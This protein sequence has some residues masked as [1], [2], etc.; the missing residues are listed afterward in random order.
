M[1]DVGHLIRPRAQY[2]FYPYIL[3]K[4]ECALNE[5]ECSASTHTPGFISFAHTR[6]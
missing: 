3:F 6:K 4:V 5:T 2:I 1:L